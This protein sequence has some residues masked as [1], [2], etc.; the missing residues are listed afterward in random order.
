MVEK[1][2]RDLLELKKEVNKNYAKPF[3]PPE[4]I[5]ANAYIIYESDAKRSKFLRKISL[6]R[7]ESS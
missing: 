4:N 3:N 2:K 5:T 6:I 7:D 1:E